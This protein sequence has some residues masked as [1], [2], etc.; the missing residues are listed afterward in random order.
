MKGPVR[1]SHIELAP[2]Q[3]SYQKLMERPSRINQPLPLSQM[4]LDEH[5]L[6][7]TVDLQQLGALSGGYLDLSKRAQ[8]L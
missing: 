8:R 1:V 7:H 2:I 4:V 6:F 3:L 5:K